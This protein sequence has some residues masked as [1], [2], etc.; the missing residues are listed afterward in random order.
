M[1][2]NKIKKKHSHPYSAPLEN[3]LSELEKG[4]LKEKSAIQIIAVLNSGGTI[5]EAPVN[6]QSSSQPFMIN[7]STESGFYI[8]PFSKNAFVTIK[9]VFYVPHPLTW[10]RL[11]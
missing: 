1:K 6:L 7:T 5:L 8:L 9:K 2:N 11:A 3:I 4:G 10:P